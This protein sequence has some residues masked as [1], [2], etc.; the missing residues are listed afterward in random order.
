VIERSGRLA[1]TTNRSRCSV[2]LEANQGNPSPPLR[3]PAK[4]KGCPVLNCQVCPVNEHYKSVSV[5][6]LELTR[7][8]SGYPVLTDLKNTLPNSQ[9]IVLE[10]SEAVGRVLEDLHFSMEA[11]GDGIVA[12]EAP[13]GGDLGGPG[14]ERFAELRQLRQAGPAATDRRPAG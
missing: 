3:L 2:T 10:F 5:G 12:C 11:F 9:P 7:F 14:V 1:S 4:C 6:L 13:H 8:P